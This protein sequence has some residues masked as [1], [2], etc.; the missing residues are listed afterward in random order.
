MKAVSASPDDNAATQ[1]RSRLSGCN[2]LLSAIL[3]TSEAIFVFFLREGGLRTATLCVETV[4]FAIA[5]PRLSY[6]AIKTGSPRD[7][8]LHARKSDSFSKQL[9]KK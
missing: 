1:S 6:L 2:S 3:S 4:E 7:R 8:R 5:S 9:F